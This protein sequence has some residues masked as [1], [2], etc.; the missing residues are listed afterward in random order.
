MSFHSFWSELLSFW[1]FVFRTFVLRPFVLRPF[2][3]Q[4]FVT[5]PPKKLTTFNILTHFKTWFDGLNEF[6]DL[7]EDEFIKE[8]TG[9]ISN[10]TFGRGLLE[11][12]DE[13]K[14]HEESERYFD[15]IRFNRAYVPSSYSSKSYG[16]SL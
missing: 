13:E 12:S 6:D 5:E 15:E 10:T 7:P 1:P 16:K 2:V 4:P 8:K 11:P 3:F 9:L 14:V